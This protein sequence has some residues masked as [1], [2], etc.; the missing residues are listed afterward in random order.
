M[1]AHAQHTE[2]WCLFGEG[3]AEEQ[4]WTTARMQEQKGAGE[5]AQCLI[6]LYRGILVRYTN[7]RVAARPRME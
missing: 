2:A 4:G 5:G 3:M 6:L 7:T 1:Y